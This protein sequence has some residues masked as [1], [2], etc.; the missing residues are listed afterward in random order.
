MPEALYFTL[1]GALRCAQYETLL[2]PYLAAF[3]RSK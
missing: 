2:R 1:G 3:P